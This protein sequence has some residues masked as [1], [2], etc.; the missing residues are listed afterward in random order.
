MLRLLYGKTHGGRVR[1]QACAL[2]FRMSHALMQGELN[3][4]FKFSAEAMSGRCSGT[5]M[6]SLGLP[7]LRPI[8]WSGS[9]WQAMWQKRARSST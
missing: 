8:W 1:Q 5:F 7:F 6:R 2:L 4:V 3:D 9:T